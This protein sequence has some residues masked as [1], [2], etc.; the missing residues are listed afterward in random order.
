MDEIRE[1]L[2]SKSFSDE[3]I[4]HI[5][6]I[7]DDEFAA[8]HLSDLKEFLSFEGGH[9][10]IR[11]TMAS[12]HTKHEQ[13]YS[14]A[15]GMI[16]RFFIPEIYQLSTI[17]ECMGVIFEKIDQD[18]DVVFLTKVRESIKANPEVIAL[19]TGIPGYNFLYPPYSIHNLKTA[20][21]ICYGKA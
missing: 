3:D 13:Y 18:A 19:V 12:L 5:I 21:G 17:N 7:F 9:K 16:I 15:K 2:R 4:K 1:Y 20:K 11:S 10:V 8:A 6:Q 14:G